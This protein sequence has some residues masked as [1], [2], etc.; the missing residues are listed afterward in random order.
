MK[1]LKISTKDPVGFIDDIIDKIDTNSIR[2]WGYNDDIFYHK[3]RQYIDHVYFEY[4]ID[5]D[6]GIIEFILQSD[7]NEFAELKVP[8][9]LEEML[10]RHFESK[11]AIL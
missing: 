7:G 9:L 3:G 1:T 2:T 11:V 6:K 8:H 5:E 4:K 10:L